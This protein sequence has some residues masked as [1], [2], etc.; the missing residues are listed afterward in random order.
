MTVS[1]ADLYTHKRVST[2][3]AV[4]PWIRRLNTEQTKLRVGVVGYS[5]QDFDYIAA[6]RLIQEAF[7]DISPDADVEIVSG[8]TDLGIPALAYQEAVR[9]GWKTVG[10]A[11][12]KAFDYSC[13]PVDDVIIYGDNWGDESHVFLTMIDVLIR[14]GGGTQSHFEACAAKREGK[15]VIEF[16]LPAL[17]SA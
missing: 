14:I 8:L 7:D 12:A 4:V 11:C 1:S 15:R 10:I 2:G 17:V 16:D 6:L 5:N 3:A 9:R 13:F